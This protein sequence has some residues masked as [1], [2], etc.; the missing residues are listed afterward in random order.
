MLINYN[1]LHTNLNKNVKIEGTSTFSLLYID[2]LN[3]RMLCISIGDSLY[4]I[5]RFDNESHKYR[6]EFISKEKYHSFNT[7][8]Q[9][10]KY[11]DSPEFLISSN[12]NILENDIIILGNDCFWDNISIEFVRGLYTFIFLYSYYHYD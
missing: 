11:G 7:P 3:M 5:M 4:S 6:M 8:Y 9:V 10:G 12:H 1:Y 2:K